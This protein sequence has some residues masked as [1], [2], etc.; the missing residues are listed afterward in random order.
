MCTA[1]AAND[2]TAMIE[3]LQIACSEMPEVIKTMQCA[4]ENVVE[5]GRLEADE[6]GLVLALPSS[7]GHLDG[8]GCS[9]R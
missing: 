2:D 7:Q 1:L 8:G 6:S 4:L 9:S 5:D 3:V